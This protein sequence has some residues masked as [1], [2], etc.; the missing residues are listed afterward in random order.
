MNSILKKAVSVLCVLI[1]LFG[2]FSVSV[3]AATY[4]NDL[5][6]VYLVGATQPVYDKEGNQVWPVEKSVAD[7]LLDNSSELLSAFNSSLLK[8]DWS[9]YGAAL[10]KVLGDSYS[11]VALDKNGNAQNGTYIN[12]SSSPKKKTSN[13][14]LKGYYF[15]YDPRLDPWSTAKKLSDYIDSVLKATGKKKVNLIGRCMGGCFISAYLVRYGCSKVDTAIYYASA[16][17]GSTVC[18]ELFSGKLDFNS[19]SINNYATDYMGDDEL[20]ELFSAIINFTYSMNMLGMGTSIINSIFD[21]LADEI[22]P[23]LLRVTYANMPSY[24]AMVGEEYYEEAKAF[25]FGGYEKEYAGLI[26]KIDNYNKKVKI[27]LDSKLKEFKKSGMKIA[28]IA[29]YNTPFLP[30]LESHSVQGDGQVSLKDISFGATGAVFGET[31]NADY[32]R[33]AQSN[34]TIDYI[35]DDLIVDASTCL[36]PDYTWFVRDI[37]HSEIPEVINN[38]K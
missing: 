21:E 23:R 18:G 15:K 13:F 30:F 27:P 3:S 38:L 25:V 7:I 11:D 6:T 20:S 14:T 17:K 29:K 9:I 16:A 12:E 28:V 32:I 1:T 33:N 8:S 37:A 4:E 10:E 35:S 19:K 36:F 5:P 31:F 24:W 34:G 26:K 2:I 22:F